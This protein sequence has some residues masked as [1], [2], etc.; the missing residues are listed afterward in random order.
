MANPLQQLAAEAR[1]YGASLR[2]F[3]RNARLYLLMAVLLAVGLG[4]QT[5]IYNLYRADIATLFPGLANSVGPVGYRAIDTTKYAN[6]VHTIA[7]VVTDSAGQAE[8][9]GSRY[10]NI[11]NGNAVTAF[12]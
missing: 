7:W 12:K 6:G 11:Q 3:N 9:I 1:V 10:F 4:V 8:G 5:V 2:Q